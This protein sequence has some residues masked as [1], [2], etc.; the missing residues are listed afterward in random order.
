MK[1]LL[2]ANLSPRIARALS[3]GGFATTH[4]C[5][6]GLVTAPDEKIL[7]FALQHGHVIVSA[8]T[9]FVTLVALGGMTAP[10]VVLLR[11]ADRLPPDDQAALLLANLPAV[12]ADLEAGAIVT[13]TRFHLRVRRLPV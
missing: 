5:E 12:V 13:L 2:D 3:V 1:F 8:D 10:S 7:A 9:D 4:V 11:S 6:H